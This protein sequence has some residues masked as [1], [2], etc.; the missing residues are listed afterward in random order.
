M[1]KAGPSVRS[2]RV[3]HGGN[4]DAP[5][6]EEGRRKHERSL[7]FY[8]VIALTLLTVLALAFFLVLTYRPFMQEALLR[9][10]ETAL[11]R[12]SKPQQVIGSEIPRDDAGVSHC[13]WSQKPSLPSEY[14]VAKGTVLVF[15][16][17]TSHNVWLM[18]TQEAFDSCDFSAARELAST[19]HGGVASADVDRLGY[20]NV[21][22]HAAGRADTV[23]YFAC[24]IS[25]HC[26]K[27]Q[28]ISVRVEHDP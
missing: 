20:A 27:G 10:K 18:P 16:Y 21:Y 2:W 7:A 12:S 8:V 22:A 5:L 3:V 4:L 19:S 11:M 17:S 25:D 6:L 13:F 15:R 26:D 24:Q 9:S 28:K 1:G 14:T 23:L